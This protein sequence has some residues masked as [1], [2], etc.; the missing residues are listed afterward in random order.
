[1]LQID[2]Q[3]K[4]EKEEDERAAGCVDVMLEP[5]SF[6]DDRRGHEASVNTS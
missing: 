1:M 5:T 3:E 4:R 6:L 2:L